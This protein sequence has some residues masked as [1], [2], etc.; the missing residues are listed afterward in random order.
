MMTGGIQINQTNKDIVDLSS[1]EI[2]VPSSNLSYSCPPLPEV[3]FLHVQEGNHYC[4][5]IGTSF[6]D[7][8]FCYKFTEG[9]WRSSVNLTHFTMLAPSF[10]SS[11]GF[12][13]MGSL[14]L[15]HTGENVSSQALLVD[16]SEGPRALYNLTAPSL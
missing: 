1:V 15:Q 11:A 6:V 5:G 9:S 13:I 16:G 14:D 12:V 10:D 7:G 8:L 4:G 3:R 2:Y